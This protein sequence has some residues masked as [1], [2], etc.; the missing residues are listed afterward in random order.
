MMARFAIM[1]SLS[2]Q[3][4]LPLEALVS[5]FSHV[6]FEPSGYTSNPE[7]PIAKSIVDYIFRWLASKFYDEE[8]KDAIGIIRRE[9]K[10]EGPGAAVAEAEASA[11]ASK[12]KP[13]PTTGKPH[14]ASGS[15][16]G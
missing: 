8:S 1:V 10:T 4:G 11:T 7:I 15:D 6:R 3:N 13:K 14:Q 2:L 12:P 9:P 16:N 5:K